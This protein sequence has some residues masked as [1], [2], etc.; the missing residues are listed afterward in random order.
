MIILTNAQ[1]QDILK[2]VEDKTYTNRIGFSIGVVMFFICLICC[3]LVS[4][5]SEAFYDYLTGS[6]MGLLLVICTFKDILKFRNVKY[7][8]ESDSFVATNK[9]V[10]DVSINRTV[11]ETDYSDTFKNS[12]LHKTSAPPRNFKVTIHKYYILDKYSN[13][14]EC[15]K[16]LDYKRCIERG[17]FIA[18][19]FPTGERLALYK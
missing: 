7:Q 8:L 11:K 13:K 3:I 10:K 5:D 18:V 15:I 6:S 19:D 17:E 9:Y 2:Y 1:K 4:K 14:Y 12:T 16:Y